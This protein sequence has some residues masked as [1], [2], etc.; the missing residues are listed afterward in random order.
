MTVATSPEGDSVGATTRSVPVGGDPRHPDA[1]E[2]GADR[3]QVVAGLL[4]PE[5]AEGGRELAHR[6]GD[7]PSL[8]EREQV[9]GGGHAVG[10]VAA[11]ELQADLGGAAGPDDRPTADAELD[12]TD[13]RLLPKRPDELGQHPLGGQ[14]VHRVR[15][16]GERDLRDAG[17]DRH[18]ETVRGARGEVAAR[19]VLQVRGRPGQQPAHQRRRELVTAGHEHRLGDHDLGRGVE[20]VERGPLVPVVEP[21][22]RH[23]EGVGH[24]VDAPLAVLLDQAEG[25]G[26][27]TAGPLPGAARV[28]GVDVGPA[29][30]GPRCRPSGR[31][32]R[33]R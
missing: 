29:A 8:V 28:V 9:V 17:G 25:E 15:V 3:A 4:L 13:A 6:T 5:R 2:A 11:A 33:R 23:D 20:V 32:A 7:D 14:L 26:G 24:L 12:G 21:R 22:L 31:R 19:D 18:R 30:P 10:V 27:A 1:G 16:A